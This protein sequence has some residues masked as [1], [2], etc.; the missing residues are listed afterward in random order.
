MR[1][2]DLELPHHYGGYII[3]EQL[4]ISSKVPQLQGDSQHLLADFK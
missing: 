2:N 4:L 1:N 3:G